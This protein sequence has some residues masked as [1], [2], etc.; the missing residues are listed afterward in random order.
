[1]HEH[2]RREDLKEPDTIE[3]FVRQIYNNQKDV[4]IPMMSDLKKCVFG[5]GEKGLKERVIILESEK[6]NK[7]RLTDVI[8]SIAIIV[9][10]IFDLIKK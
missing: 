9:L 10:G 1:M 4:V 8:L 5:N 7:M 2:E 6:R 3:E